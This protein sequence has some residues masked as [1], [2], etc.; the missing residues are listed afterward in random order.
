MGRKTVRKTSPSIL[1]YAHCEQ[2]YCSGLFGVATSLAKSNCD[3]HIC[4]LAEASVLGLSGGEA[5]GHYGR[6]C[7]G[8]KDAVYGRVES[9]DK[10]NG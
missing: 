4:K 2:Y 8:K 5:S 6:S 7:A 1:V 10:G 9:H 3:E